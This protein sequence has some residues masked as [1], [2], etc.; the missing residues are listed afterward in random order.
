MA[1][2]NKLS[3]FLLK[4]EGGFSDNPKDRGKATMKGVTLNTF[5]EY[6]KKEGR[7]IP[8]SVNAQI[9][10]LKNISDSDWTDIMKRLYWD[11][12]KA[13]EISY[14]SIANILVDWAYNSGVATSIMGFQK[15]VPTLTTDG[16]V[17]S[18]TIGYINNSNELDLFNRILSARKTYYVNLAR[19][20][21]SQM[22]FLDGWL[23]RLF[24]MVGYNFNLTAKYL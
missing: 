17:G 22:I 15:L 2:A 4:W 10:L 16:I 12:W 24:D 3:P 13:D 1:T 18:K 23:N 11:K 5:K 7:T 8:S 21:C 19:N 20:N 6:L 9:T 14:Q